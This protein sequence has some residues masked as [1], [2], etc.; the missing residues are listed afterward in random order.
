METGPRL[1]IVGAGPTGLGAAWRLH[2][3]GATRWL[4]VDAAQEAGGLAGSV[5]DPQ[6]FV[7]DRGGHVLFSHYEYFDRAV[8]TW[9]GDAWVEHVREAWVWMRRRFIP[10][11]LQNNIWRLPDAELERCIAGL[12]AARKETHAERPTQ[13]R[14]WILRQFGAGLAESFF[15]PYNRK[16]WAYDPARLGTGWMGERVATVDLARVLANVERRQDD[17]GW[18]P[19]ARFRFPLR[20][21]TGAIWRAALD[22]LPRER[23][24]LGRR[25]VRI[26]AQRKTAVFA[27]GGELTYDVLLSTMPLD[28]LLTLLVDQPQLAQQAGEFVHSRTHLVGVGIEGDTP[29]VLRTKNWMYFPEPE[30]PFYRVTVFSNYSP[31][32]VPWPGQQWSLLCEMSSTPDESF[33]DE[34][35]ERDVV[36][37]LRGEGFLQADVTP[38]TLWRERLEYGYPTPFVGRDE[39][40][41]RVDSRLKALS[42]Y[43]RGRFGGWKYE[44]SNQ[45]HSLMQGVEWVE[46]VLA[47]GEETTYYDPDTVNRGPQRV[48]PD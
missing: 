33:D 29:E 35:H 18:G 40:L 45:D 5:V 16:V 19:N 37:A 47:G 48:G 46:H 1:L 10:Y 9:L 14:E 43:S 38:V 21:G 20:G 2:Q 15:L 26:D 23:V 44:V 34:A 32:N 7:W 17:V 27:D 4:L 13:F 25:V 42:I 28:R 22:R 24:Q 39:L 3:R 6:G 8:N 41:A 11:P 30:L 12:R 31:H 36:A